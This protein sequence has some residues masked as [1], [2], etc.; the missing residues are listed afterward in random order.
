MT[1]IRTHL[2]LTTPELGSDELNRSATTVRHA[3]YGIYQRILVQS[4]MYQMVG[5]VE[6]LV[7]QGL[8][9]AQFP[10]YLCRF[11]KMLNV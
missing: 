3:K 6:V 1:G 5:C 11:V 9:W 8:V 10:M 2:L 4:F 7:R